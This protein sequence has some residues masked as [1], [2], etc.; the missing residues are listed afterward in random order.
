M[1]LEKVIAAFQRLVPHIPDVC[2]L[3]MQKI[4]LWILG[5]K[6]ITEYVFVS[7]HYTFS[8]STVHKFLYYLHLHI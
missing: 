1:V 6:Q 8:I 5:L 2:I 4:Y 3:H 7:L